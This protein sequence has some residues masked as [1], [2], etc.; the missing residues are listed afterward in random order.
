M[1]ITTTP[2]LVVYSLGISQCSVCTS[3]TPRETVRRVNMDN[4]TGLEYKW[5]IDKLSKFHT[6]ESN[7]CACNDHPETHKHYLMV[8]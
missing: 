5:K 4:P 7:P 2:D 6:G 1:T 3:L 8:C